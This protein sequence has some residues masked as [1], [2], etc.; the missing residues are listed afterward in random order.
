MVRGVRRS[1]PSSTTR[2]NS[3]GGEKASRALPIAVQYSGSRPPTREGSDRLPVPTDLQDVDDLATVQ[4]AEVDRLVRAFVEVLHEGGGDLQQP[5]F[6]GRAHAELED[7][8]AQPVS[9]IGPVEQADVH[10]VTD[11]PV[12]RALRQPGPAL[13]LRQ[14][15]AMVVDLE[16]EEDRD[17]LAEH[18]AQVRGRIAAARAAHRVMLPPAPVWLSVRSRPRGPRAAGAAPHR[19]PR[20][21]G[22]PSAG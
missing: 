13:E 18:R 2:T 12:Q 17:D 20:P 11:H 6:H 14:A 16:G 5:T 15:E 22:A 3:S 21:A 4:H 8:H 9:V 10:Q 1:S 19:G 7:L